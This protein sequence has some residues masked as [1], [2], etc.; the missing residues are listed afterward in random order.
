MEEKE[1]GGVRRTTDVADV[2]KYSGIVVVL[3]RK[4]ATDGNSLYVYT[5][6]YVKKFS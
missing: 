2:L 3:S 1:G 5:F 4:L 6:F